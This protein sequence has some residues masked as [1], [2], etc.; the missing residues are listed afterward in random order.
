MVTEK[1][2]LLLYY[3]RHGQTEA[4]A[5]EI[6][7]VMQEQGLSCR[8]M[9][10]SAEAVAGFS[11]QDYASVLFGM[12]VHYG[13]HCVGMVKL[14]GQHVPLLQ[15][16][17]AA[18]FSVNLTARKPDKN[19]AQTNPYMHKLLQQLHWQPALTGVF[20]GALRYPQYRFFDRFMI[21]LIMKMTGGPVDT[22]VPCTEFTDREQVRD[23]ARDY[24]GLIRAHDGAAG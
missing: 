18:L 8:R 4:I 7:R 11:P 1:P 12:P 24:T 9:R 10:F 21:R 14:I 5:V 3:S 17:P 23:F 16:M 6:A 15:C 20:A 22:K 19:T 13:K 2:H